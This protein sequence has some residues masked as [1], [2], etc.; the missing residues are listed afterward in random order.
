MR[1]KQSSTALLCLVLALP[2]GALA[3]GTLPGAAAGAAAGGAA[4]GPVGAVVGG[5]AGAAA[6][7]VGGVVGAPARGPCASTTVHRENSAG[8]SQTVHR[9]DC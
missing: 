6:G 7:T 4:A 3:Q 9:T 1:I 8:Q 2:T 5:A